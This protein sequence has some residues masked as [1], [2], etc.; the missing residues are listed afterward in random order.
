MNIKLKLHFYWMKNGLLK[1]LPALS[2]FLLLLLLLMSLWSRQDVYC[3]YY[4][5]PVQCASS[6]FAKHRKNRHENQLI[7]IKNAGNWKSRFL[8]FLWC[9]ARESQAKLE[10]QENEV[11]FR[12]E[13]STA[14]SD[15]QESDTFAMGKT[16]DEVFPNECEYLPHRF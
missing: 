8:L 3:I 13:D 6:L 7:W 11:R 10:K 1:F 14:K 12:R 16:Q 15:E 9:E 2:L 4:Y 5:V